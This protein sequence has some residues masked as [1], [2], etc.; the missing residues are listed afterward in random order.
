MT[1]D[2]LLLRWATNWRMGAW[3]LR[4]ALFWLRPKRDLTLEFTEDGMLA[5]HAYPLSSCRV[6]AI[7]LGEMSP[8]GAFPIRQMVLVYAPQVDALKAA[9]PVGLEQRLSVSLAAGHAGDGG[10]AAM[11]HGD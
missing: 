5:A 11:L 7:H 8:D 1:Y 10:G 9:H 2:R 3:W 4:Y 6:I